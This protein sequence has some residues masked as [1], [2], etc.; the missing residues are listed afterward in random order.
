MEQG[1]SHSAAARP[2]NIC[3][4]RSALEE[5]G[6]SRRIGVISSTGH[7]SALKPATCVAPHTLQEA[8]AC[9]LHLS[10]CAKIGM[11]FFSP[12]TITDFIRYGDVD[13]ARRRLELGDDVNERRSL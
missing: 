6:S 3:S 13:G 9:G 10:F 7:W 12:D 4:A 2:G 11:G 8:I 5:M 1:A